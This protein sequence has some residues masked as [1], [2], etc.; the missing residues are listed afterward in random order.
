[1]VEKETFAL[2]LQHHKKKSYKIEK[3]KKLLGILVLGLL[4]NNAKN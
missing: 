2:A 1:M 3:M 4:A